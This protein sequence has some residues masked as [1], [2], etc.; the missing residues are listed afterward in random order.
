[1][2]FRSARRLG[3]DDVVRT[4]APV[5]YLISLG[6]QKAADTL[7]L[8]LWDSPQEKSVLTGKLFEYVGAGRPILSLGCEDGAAGSLVRERGLGLATSN[9]DAVC[10]YLLKTAAAKAR[11]GAA[12]PARGADA[13][14]GLS[15]REQFRALERFLGAHGLLVERATAK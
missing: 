12:R 8:L 15:R 6:L 10:S 11:S 5:P 14:M 1:M 2:L 4:F 9:V 7:L 3:V 13:I